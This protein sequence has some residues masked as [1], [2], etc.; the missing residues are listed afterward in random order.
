MV[1]IGPWQV[2]LFVYAQKP[3][4]PETVKGGTILFQANS[5]HQL[6]VYLGHVYF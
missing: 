5:I 3:K 4:S 2:D 6:L 1:M